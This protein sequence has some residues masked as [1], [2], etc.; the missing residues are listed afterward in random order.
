MQYSCFFHIS[1]AGQVV[2]V[3]SIR[4]G[5]GCKKRL[6]GFYG[7][8]IRFFQRLCGVLLGYGQ[9]DIFPAFRWETLVELV[10]IRLFIRRHVHIGNIHRLCPFLPAAYACQVFVYGDHHIGHDVLCDL[11]LA[12]VEGGRGA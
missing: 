8:V 9:L 11:Y 4:Y 6:V 10:C 12:P 1:K 2:L 3:C 7:F 5:N